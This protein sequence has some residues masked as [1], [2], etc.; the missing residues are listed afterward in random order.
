MRE[1]GSSRVFQPK[2]RR[3]REQTLKG[4]IK[5]KHSYTTHRKVS[6]PW[7]TWEKTER[8]GAKKQHTQIKKLSY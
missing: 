2:K 1:Q 6:F 4:C 7:V 3:M 5:K 8:T